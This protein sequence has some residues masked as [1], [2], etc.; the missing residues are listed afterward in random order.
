MVPVPSVPGFPRFSVPGFPLNGDV[1]G[2]VDSGSGLSTKCSGDCPDFGPPSATVNGNIDALN[3]QAVQIIGMVAA[4]TYQFNKQ[5]NC[6][7]GAAY[8]FIPGPKPEDFAFSDIVENGLE[9]AAQKSEGAAE[10]I[11]KAY[12][13]GQGRGRMQ[14]NAAKAIKRA[15]VLGAAAKGIE[16]VGYASAAQDGIKNFRECENR[17]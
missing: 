10:A 12:R 2:N 14:R 9:S 11:K 5:L 7:A 8:P 13:L 6:L 1:V 16:V 17:Q 15:K 4:E 3:P